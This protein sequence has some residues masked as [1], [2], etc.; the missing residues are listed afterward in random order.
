MASVC[1]FEVLAASLISRPSTIR[2][3]AHSTP[4]RVRHFATTRGF[5]GYNFGM[6]REYAGASC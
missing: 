2:S 5:S 6:F 4:N 3:T 1:R